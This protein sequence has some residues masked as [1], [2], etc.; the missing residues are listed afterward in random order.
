MLTVHPSLSLISAPR[1]PLALACAAVLGAGRLCTDAGAGV[2]TRAGARVFGPA[3]RGGARRP[4]GKGGADRRG[5]QLG[6]A[7][8][9]GERDSSS[10]IAQDEKADLGEIARLFQTAAF[11]RRFIE[12][13]LSETDI[14]PTVNEDE[15]ETMTKVLDL[16]GADKPMEA[17]DV[18]ESARGESTSAVLDFTVGNIYYQTDD[19]V[20]AEG[21]YLDA[22]AKFPNFRRAWKNLAQIHFRQGHFKASV[23]AFS[24][25]LQLGGGDG[26]TYG[27]MGRCACAYEQPDCGRVG[28]PPG[29]DARSRH[30]RLEARSRGELLQAAPPTRMRSRSSIS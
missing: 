17:A 27:L 3:A 18:L 1:V 7:A 25:V 24:K 20:R 12:S 6:C 26:I 29:D 22:V 10:A 2:R 28:I 5:Q 23:G 16:I 13:F 30:D 15:R 19:L 4:Q 14:E 9:G 8:V 11:Q 21:A